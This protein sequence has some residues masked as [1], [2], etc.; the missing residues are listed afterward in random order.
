MVAAS[1]W[2]A[3]AVA[4]SPT[5]PY[6]ITNSEAR[7][8]RVRTTSATP[9]CAARRTPG[10]SGVSGA[11]C[12]RAART[13]TTTSAAAEPSWARSVPSAEPATPRSRP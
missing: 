10:R 1:W 6:V 3:V 11:P 13:T 12:A 2:V 4:P 9:A 8:V 7:R 5:A